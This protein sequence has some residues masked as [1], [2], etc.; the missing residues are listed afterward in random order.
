[1]AV[2]LYQIHKMSINELNRHFY[3]IQHVH[4]T[5][6]LIS[7]QIIRFGGYYYKDFGVIIRGSSKP[8]RMSTT[9]CQGEKYDKMIK[10]KMTGLK[11]TG[12]FSGSFLAEKSR[13]SK[14]GD[15]RNKRP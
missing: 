9:K 1:M 13:K 4:L 5:L 7:L 15:S 8:I 14:Y 10:L 3:C 11:I 6:P 12:F 2:Y